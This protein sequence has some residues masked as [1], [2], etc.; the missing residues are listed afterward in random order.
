MRTV[1]F[2]LCCVSVIALL[3]PSPT[4]AQTPLGTAFTYQGQLKTGGAPVDGDFNMIFTLWNDPTLS[5]PDNQVAPALIFDGVG[6]NPPP[7]AV[8]NGLFDVEL[9]FGGVYNGQK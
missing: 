6:G 7:I 4:F 1:S 5:A 2:G 9:A 3:Q 8:A